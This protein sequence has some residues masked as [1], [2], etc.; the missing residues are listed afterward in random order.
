MAV[1][2]K[3]KARLGSEAFVA[4]EEGSGSHSKA[5]HTVHFASYWA[6]YMTDTYNSHLP[7]AVVDCS[8][9]LWAAFVQAEHFENPVNLGLFSFFAFS[10]YPQPFNISYINRFQN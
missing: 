4:R 6:V 3:I 2:V 1:I 5:V 9:L 7:A 8:C 10:F